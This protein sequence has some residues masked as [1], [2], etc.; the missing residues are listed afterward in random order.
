MQDKG[1]LGWQDKHLNREHRENRE[2]GK[3]KKEPDSWKKE[4]C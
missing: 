3:H 4:D 2:Q 1:S